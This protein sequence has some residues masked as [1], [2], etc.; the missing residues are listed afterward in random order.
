MTDRLPRDR[1]RALAAIADGTYSGREPTTAHP[2]CKCGKPV[3]CPPE[4]DFDSDWYWRT[5]SELETTQERRQ[6]VA[7]HAAEWDKEW[8]A[9]R[10]ARDAALRCP[11]HPNGPGGVRS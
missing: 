6:F 9:W 4:P 10:A 3:Q 11:M 2:M 1:E 5:H 8:L 7:R